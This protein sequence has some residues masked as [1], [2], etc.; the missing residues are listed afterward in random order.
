[1]LNTMDAIHSSV[2]VAQQQD[3]QEAYLVAYVIS[4]RGDFDKT[5]V[6]EKLQQQL[7]DYMVPQI[8]V[9]IEKFPKTA[10][11]KVDRKALSSLNL[12]Y[13]R[14]KEKQVRSVSLLQ[15]KLNEFFISILELNFEIGI[16][17]SF[18]ALGGHSLN[19]VKL[20]FMI[21]EELKCRIS[22]KNIFENP[23]I[24]A[25]ADFLENQ[26]TQQLLLIPKIDKQLHYS[27]Y[28]A[29][30]LLWLA[31]QRESTSIAY[32]M[33][34]LYE[35]KGE[36]D[37]QI[38]EEAFLLV[39][40]K[41]DILRSNFVEIAGVPNQKIVEVEELDFK[42]HQHKTNKEDRETWIDAFLHRPFDLEN[43]LLFR[44]AC[45]EVEGDRDYLIFST[46]HLISDGWSLE[47]LIRKVVDNYQRLYLKKSVQDLPLPFQFQDYVYYHKSVL[48]NEVV[49]NT[50]FWRGYLKSYHWT[51]LNP[52]NI[53]LKENKGEAAE[54]QFTWDEQF[55]DQI[56]KNAVRY[57][58][59]VHT[60][61][62]SAFKLLIYKLY[63][64]RD[65][66][67]GTLS[68]GRNMAQLEDQMGMF[69]KTLPLR[70]RF[71]ENLMTSEYIER[72]NND[73]LKIDQHQDI[74]EEI[75]R[76]IKLDVLF[77]LQT[78]GFHNKRI[79]VSDE[80]MF[81]RLE[82]PS[83]FARLP[84]LINIDQKNHSFEGV[85]VYN[86]SLWKAP[87]IKV[88]MLKF[89]VLLE[90]LMDYPEQKINTINTDLPYEKKDTVDIPLNF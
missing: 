5:K 32:N 37:W 42:I 35:V 40:N 4:D 28:P 57:G 72:I 33:N 25:L 22:L 27:L 50:D 20:Q 56:N 23:T 43:D 18:F 84:L 30:N 13:M 12:S 6:I 88:M 47:L 75:Q 19:A 14:P 63:D 58:C 78:Q 21:E 34:G 55:Y 81:R 74:P 9:P 2:V 64:I 89:R 45:L 24:A 46:H 77:V 52:L 1:R 44:V 87:L 15:R 59:T 38:L 83:K 11:N 66:C 60:L 90:S 79:Q 7:P 16:H 31:A 3:D 76:E 49:K 36:L 29:Q 71:A 10:N 8:I 82:L 86:T 68:V 80:L 70:T 73:V 62:I 69:V 85:V 26:P 41:Y 61:L 53:D 17:D 54:Y 48:K 51:P 39:L 65:I 67:I